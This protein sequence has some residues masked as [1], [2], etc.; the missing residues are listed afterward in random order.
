MRE[1]MKRAVAVRLVCALAL[2]MLGFSG[3]LPAVANPGPYS[4]EYM[5]PD[6]TFASLCLPSEEEHGG[7]SDGKHCDVC[8]FAIGHTFVLPSAAGIV[9]PIF[10]SA[11]TNGPTGHDNL[12]R[13]LSYH[14]Q[15]RGP[16]LEA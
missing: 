2:F 15:S 4:A 6:G 8:I 9:P 13:I 12:K 14:G 7:H 3:S 1:W 5:L 10:T 11:V 16:P